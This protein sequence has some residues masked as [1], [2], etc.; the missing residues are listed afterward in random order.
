MQNFNPKDQLDILLQLERATAE[1]NR[2]MSERSQSVLK[3]YPISFALL[4]LLGVVMVSEGTKGIL[5][6]LGILAIRPWYLLGLGVI[7]LAI[8]GSVYK[9]LDK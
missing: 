9:K 8:L 2:L 4:A 6:T 1:L 7:L 5:S 3:R